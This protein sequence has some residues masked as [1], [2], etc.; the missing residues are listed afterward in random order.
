MARNPIP[1]GR[2]APCEAREKSRRREKRVSGEQEMG[3]VVPPKLVFSQKRRETNS[4]EVDDV[5]HFD[6]VRGGKLRLGGV[7]LSRVKGSWG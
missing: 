7:E 6:D 1:L 3:D 4:D 2:L 5:G